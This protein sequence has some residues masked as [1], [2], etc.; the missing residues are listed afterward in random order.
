MKI[1]VINTGSSSIKYVLFEMSG[2]QVL[3]KGLVDRIGDPASSLTN[4]FF[5]PEER[6]EQIT[7]PIEDHATGLELVVDLLT[8]DQHEIIQDTN[9]IEAVGHRVVHGGEHFD[10]AE[11]IDEGIKATI[12]EL[13]TLA[14][15]HNPSNLKGIEVAEKFFPNAKQVA[16]FDTAFHQTM[17]AQSFRYPIPN[18]L[19]TNNKIRVYGMHG[20]SH[21]YVSKQLIR[22]LDKPVEQTSVISIH[23]GNGCSMAAIKG[24]KCI[25][26]SMGLSPL[27]GLMMGTRSGDLDPAV[28]FYLGTTLG[29]TLEDIDRTLNK[30]SGLKG[31]AGSNDMRDVLAQR[32]SGDE[33]ATLAIDMYVQRIKKYIGAYTAEL[34]GLDAIAFTAGIGENSDELRALV[35]EGLG[36]LGLELDKEKNQKRSSENRCISTAASGVAIWVVPTNEELEIALQSEKLLAKPS[37]S[38]TRRF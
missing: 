30:E 9:D 14:P 2:R 1:L 31:I 21:S 12:R 32:A 7:T 33:N 16:V 6:K 13:S 15:L 28:P 20:T 5:A 18:E 11:L 29:M 24:G 35:C 17:P 4:S 36:V 8:N 34:G 22:Q 38:A 10:R 37:Q 3:A 25:D 23:L 19:Y 27:A 26:T